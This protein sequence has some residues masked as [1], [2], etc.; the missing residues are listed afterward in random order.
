MSYRKLKADY[1][2]DGYQIRPPN[3]VLICGQ[4]GSI[5]NIVDEGQAGSGVEGFTGMIAPGFINCHCHLEL[6]HLKGLITEKQGLVNFVLS[7]MSQRFQPSASKAEA[8]LEAEREMKETGIVAVGDISN[9]SDAAFVK[10][11][12]HID[13]YHFIE[14][15]GW[16][17]EMAGSRFEAGKKLAEE[18]I[19]FGYDEKHISL[20][21]HAPYSVSA[22][23][24]DLMKTGFR[25]KTVTIHNQESFAENEFFSA[26]NGDLN[27]LYRELKMNNSHFKVPGSRSLPYYLSKLSGAERILL[28]HNTFMDE[29]D[30]IEACQFSDKLFLCLCPNANLYIENR[31]PDIPLFLKHTDRIVLGTDSLASNHQLSILEEMK[32]IKKIY[33]DVLSADMLVWATSNGAKAL[34][35]DS[36]LG[37]FTKG[38]NPGVVLIENLDGAEVCTGSTSR[39]LV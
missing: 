38:K 32:S 31:L 7:V 19:A 24:W 23:L 10:K 33:P 30:L 26:G 18:F 20:V 34:S 35:F 17:P 2:F 5:V 39:R 37:D 28:V 14:L 21:P 13:Y 16:S 8:I 25:G 22:E 9:T 3:S 27:R 36:R 6:S 11:A 4:D 1:L 29:S 15:L 12:K